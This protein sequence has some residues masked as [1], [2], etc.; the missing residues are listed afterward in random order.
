MSRQDDA[1]A[2]G[3]EQKNTWTSTT[4]FPGWQYRARLSAAFLHLERGKADAPILI[5]ASVEQ[6]AKDRSQAVASESAIPF[7]L[8]ARLLPPIPLLPAP[9]FTAS[10]DY[11]AGGLL[12]ELP[13]SVF[14][15]VISLIPLA[16]GP[17]ES[18]FRF[19]AGY[20]RIL[21]SAACDS[22]SSSCSCSSCPGI[23]LIP[24]RGDALPVID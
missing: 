7:R 18:F 3:T 16:I 24:L 5:N 13:E 17:V 22:L 8:P 19:S 10:S 21:L 12:L 15:P 1:N 14:C 23:E 20:F 6:R 4:R 2:R 9:H 11:V